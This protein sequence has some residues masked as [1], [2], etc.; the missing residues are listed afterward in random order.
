MEL[1]TNESCAQKTL[2]KIIS[3]IRTYLG[4]RIEL[5]S[6]PTHVYDM[7]EEQEDGIMDEEENFESSFETEEKEEAKQEYENDC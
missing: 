5:K 6:Q 3:N 7:E 4:G 1:K 2:R